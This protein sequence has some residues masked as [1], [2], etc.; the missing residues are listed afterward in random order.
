MRKIII[1]SV[2]CPNCGA[3]EMHPSQDRLLI[4]G[5]KVTDENG[6]SYSQCLVCAGYYDSNLNYTPE[7][8]D[9]EK[10]WFGDR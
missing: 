2:E 1:K 3:Q 6:I 7:K 8:G 10:G 9:P 4:R 5:F